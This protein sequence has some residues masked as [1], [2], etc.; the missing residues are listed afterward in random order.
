MIQFIRVA[1]VAT[2][3]AKKGLI[4]NP[5]HVKK[6]VKTATKVFDGIR[7]ER[8]RKI[9]EY[10]N[11]RKEVSRFASIANKRVKRLEVKGFN[12]SSKAYRDAFGQGISEKFGIRG[13]QNRKE[14]L[15]E[16]ERIQNFL[17]AQTSTITGFKKYLDGVAARRGEK[18]PGNDY[19]AYAN[20]Y[21]NLYRAHERL[22]QF[23]PAALPYSSDDEMEQINSVL[24]QLGDDYKYDSEELDTIVELA[25]EQYEG[26][27][28][29]TRRRRHEGITLA[30]PNVL[31]TNKA[32]P[33]DLDW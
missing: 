33:I 11:L 32:D 21:S 31:S 22:R 8:E 25:I 17:S 10:R 14:V 24:E 4:T 19:Q 1:K 13:L 7:K 29:D 26:Q 27:V 12:E 6:S 9:E 23:R 15:R 18:I 28:E 3:A 16:K 2:D 20:K 30:R 5:A